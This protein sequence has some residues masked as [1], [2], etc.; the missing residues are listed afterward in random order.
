MLSGYHVPL[1]LTLI[2]CGAALVGVALI[3]RFRAQTEPAETPDDGGLRAF[4]DSLQRT[5]E[6]TEP[7]DTVFPSS[8]KHVTR[9]RLNEGSINPVE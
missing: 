7:S 4:V 6:T 9:R 5:D 3:L 2:V 8:G 1:G